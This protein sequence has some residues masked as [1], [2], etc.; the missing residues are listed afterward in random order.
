MRL[1]S[2]NVRGLNA[3][4]KRRL[5]K[6][7]LELMKCDLVLLQE[8]KLNLQSADRLFSSWKVWNFCSSPSLGASG[9]LA[10]I[11]KD[12]AIHFSLVALSSNWMLGIVKRRTSNLKFWLFNVYGPSGIIEKRMLWNSLI[13]LTTPLQ[14]V[15][16]IFG[17]DFNAIANLN[18]KVGGIIPNKRVILDFSNFIQYLSLVDCMPL[19]GSFT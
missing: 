13:T 5:I 2:W 3:P 8:T 11:W 16:L 19:N 14:N 17:G 18:E 9:G 4:N 10:I 7:Q 1:I 12:S 15:F 6:S